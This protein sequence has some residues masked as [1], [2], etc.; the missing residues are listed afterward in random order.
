CNLGLNGGLDE[1]TKVKV[2]GIREVITKPCIQIGFLGPSN[3]GKSAVINGLF[4]KQITRTGTSGT[5]TSSAVVSYYASPQDKWE[6]CGLTQSQLEQKVKLS[7]Q[8]MKEGLSIGNKDENFE[9]SYN[10]INIKFE[11][12]KEVDPKAYELL[13]PTWEFLKVV[14]QH[15]VSPIGNKI[16]QN[17]DDFKTLVNHSSN[18]EGLSVFYGRSTGLP[19]ITTPKVFELVDVPGVGMTLQ[20]DY[21]VR[22]YSPKIDAY[23]LG[24]E[25]NKYDST[26]VKKVINDSRIDWAFSNGNADGSK[27][28]RFSQL[29][30]KI[31]TLGMTYSTGYAKWNSLRREVSNRFFLIETNNQSEKSES[32]NN[33]NSFEN[34]VEQSTVFG[35]FYSAK[36]N[37]PDLYHEHF[38]R[39]LSGLKEFETEIRQCLFDGGISKLRNFL[40]YEWPIQIVSEIIA[41]SESDINQFLKDA[42]DL[43]LKLNSL[44]ELLPVEFENIHNAR[45]ALSGI[46]IEIS[47]ARFGPLAKGL[48]PLIN[49]SGASLPYTPNSDIQTVKEHFKSLARMG[50]RKILRQL[51]IDD[52]LINECYKY[53]SHK[54]KFLDHSLRI[55][56]TNHDTEN[57][58]VLWNK[59]LPLI[60]KLTVAD[61]DHII[62]QTMPEPDIIDLMDK[63]FWET[64]TK[65]TGIDELLNGLTMVRPCSGGGNKK[66]DLID[67]VSQSLDTHKDVDNFRKLENLINESVI[68]LAIDCVEVIKN[69][70]I[71][72]INELINKIQLIDSLC[73]KA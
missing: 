49:K 15:G 64:L 53:I 24:Y 50:A 72:K 21:V 46:I 51:V 22:E 38:P 9:S 43:K 68:N 62:A 40:L 10:Q 52:G 1:K 45:I 44:L 71:E 20:D 35:S 7:I 37:S 66:I 67:W 31:A 12:F 14:K 28:I 70:L 39:H 6:I 26:E 2:K 23:I 41:K 11:A 69:F 57:L 61:N 42:N 30:T 65:K 34:L 60:R 58:D 8:N 56:A 19:P 32:L 5:A 63:K 17:H 55:S 29:I 13:K 73:S 25:V 33:N 48:V 16:I 18:P 36:L 59:T 4:K 3:I 54:G 47:K 27:T